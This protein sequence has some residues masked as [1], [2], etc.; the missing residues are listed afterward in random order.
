MAFFI[1]T[2]L[3]KRFTFTQRSRYPGTAFQCL[4]SEK[5]GV[6]VIPP[7]VREPSIDPVALLVPRHGVFI[8]NFT[9][10]RLKFNSETYGNP[11]FS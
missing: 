10:K 1:S 3:R 4:M 8:S 11:L 6:H 7:P 9:K 5:N 2:N